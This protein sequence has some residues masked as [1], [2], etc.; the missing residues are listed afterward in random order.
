M[1]KITR[2]LMMVLLCGV[3]DTEGAELMKESEAA[4]KERTR[5]FT[6]AKFG[7][8]IHF[9]VYSTLEG[10][11]QGEPAKSYAEWIQSNMKI[12][13]DDYI[14]LA[15]GFRPDKLDADAWVKTARDA[16][17]R[18]MVITTKHH[19]GFC[20]W[21]SAHTEYDL[22]EAT[23][24]DRD[25][26]G[27]L[28]A[29]CKKYGL[30]FGTYYSLTDWHHP[31]QRSDHP[32]FHPPMRDKPGYVAYMKA[33]LKELIERYDPAIMWF[34][35]DWAR[36]WTAEDGVDLY[37][38]L[39]EL[40]PELMINNRV[41]K[42]KVLKKDFGTPENNTPGAALDH[43]WEACWTINH[44]WGF[45]RHDTKW[46]SAEQLVRKQ[47]NINTKGGNLLLNVGP[48]PD[49][50]WP[51]ACTERLLAMGEW[52][53]AHHDAVYGARYVSAPPQAWGSLAQA[54]DA[55]AE[56]GELFAYI[57]RWPGNKRL[58]L[59]RLT[60]G[61]LNATSYEGKHLPTT[62]G[63][64]GV[65]IDLSEVVQLPA[66]TV[67]RLRYSGGME[68]KPKANELELNGDEI[69]LG[70]PDAKLTGA[71]ITLEGNSHIGSWTEP[72]AMATWAMDVPAP[73]R[74]AISVLYACTEDYGGSDVVVSV[75]RQRVT[76]QVP[77]NSTSWTDFKVLQLGEMELN[78]VGDTV[79]TVG[80][81]ENKGKALFNLKTV[82]LAPIA[83]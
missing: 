30:K 74:Y 48:K 7:L 38:Y 47:V 77:A 51:A 61:A 54:S 34:D 6:D 42:R 18:Y 66:V 1:L 64:D 71:N 83:E 33:Q 32:G 21:D 11:W 13:P 14:P 22:G 80:F 41:S 78:Q 17:M 57:S 67:L 5:W 29:A 44:S 28:S 39:R 27:E 68:Q 35:G 15:A 82:I 75:G 58:L 72:D 3:L 16:G 12:K 65:T 31:S 37:N 53:R 9:G 79:C 40:N 26:L 25:I 10:V 46:K 56:Q 63:P 49:G 52:N 19:E 76:A 36:W 73:G 62:V 8:F 43:L 69:V 50:S 20:L 59:E 2:V 60:F 45:K 24:F 55:T 70:A 4:F 23:P 81:G